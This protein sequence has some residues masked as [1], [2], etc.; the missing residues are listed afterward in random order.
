MCTAITEFGSE[1]L[2]NEPRSVFLSGGVFM[3]DYFD[4][5]GEEDGE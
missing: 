2:V 5:S 1:S 4:S 3:G